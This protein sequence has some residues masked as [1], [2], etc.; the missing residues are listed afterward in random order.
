MLK[1][2]HKKFKPSLIKGSV[3]IFVFFI[4]STQHAQYQVIEVPN[5]TKN[6]KVV[7]HYHE[8]SLKVALFPL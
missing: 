4:M 2:D 3:K 6:K 8:H 5:G 7:L 1:T